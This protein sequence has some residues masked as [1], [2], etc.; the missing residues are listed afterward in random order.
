MMTANPHVAAGRCRCRWWCRRRG[1]D[2]VNGGGGGSGGDGGV[3]GA[4]MEIDVK[5][6]VDGQI[7]CSMTETFSGNAQIMTSE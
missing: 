3:G 7:S 4:H 6:I 5:E 1:R 2:G